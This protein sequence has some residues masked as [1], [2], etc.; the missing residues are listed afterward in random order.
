M[1]PLLVNAHFMTSTSTM[2]TIVAGSKPSLGSHFVKPLMTCSGEP[3]CDYPEGII[4]TSMVS[5]GCYFAV[6]RNIQTLGNRELLFK[7]KET[8]MQ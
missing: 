7:R 1:L 4:S 2:K 3:N 6:T 5:E 8:I